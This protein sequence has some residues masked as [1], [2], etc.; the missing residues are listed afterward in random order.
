MATELREHLATDLQGECEA[1]GL[2]QARSLGDRSSLVEIC[3][4]LVEPAECA[5]RPSRA[6]QRP[7]E[8]AGIHL[9]ALACERAVGRDGLGRELGRFLVPTAGELAVGTH[10]QRHGEAPALARRWRPRGADRRD[11][12][13]ARRQG[14]RGPA[15]RRLAPGELRERLAELAAITARSRSG[16]PVLPHAL[17]RDREGALGKLRGGEPGRQRSQRRSE[18]G[19]RG[20]KR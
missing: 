18:V 14:V 5:A 10:G 16:G 19:A 3:E 13:A 8:G 17:L 1:H 15:E 12:L 11:R 2:R 4:R 7:G 9:L 20:A 6:A